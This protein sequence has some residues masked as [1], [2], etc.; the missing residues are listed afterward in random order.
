MLIIFLFKD[1]ENVPSFLNQHVQCLECIQLFWISRNGC[2][3]L[4]QVDK[5]KFLLHTHEEQSLL[6]GCSVGNMMPL[7]KL[8]QYYCM[9]APHGI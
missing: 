1:I 5:E 9:A 8:C 3:A 6:E 2:I 4:M 7:R